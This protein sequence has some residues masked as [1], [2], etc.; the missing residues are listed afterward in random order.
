MHHQ[1][2]DLDKSLRPTPPPT[3]RP[4]R[5]CAGSG[6]TVE[7]APLEAAEAHHGG[8]WLCC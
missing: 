6:L 5:I 4:R 2:I 3:P 8:L 7:S 1:L